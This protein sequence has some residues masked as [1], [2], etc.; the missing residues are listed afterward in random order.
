MEGALLLVVVE[1][2]GV[3]LTLDNGWSAGSPLAGV[4]PGFEPPIGVSDQVLTR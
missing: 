3:V 2:Q 1:G 4:E